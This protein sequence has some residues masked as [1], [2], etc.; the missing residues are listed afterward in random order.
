MEI[1]EISADQKTPV[2][3]H[4]WDP[5]CK[6][7]VKRLNSMERVIYGV[8]IMQYFDKDLG[9]EERAE[10]G[11]EICVLALIGEEGSPL[12]TLDDVEKIKKADFM[13]MN[14]VFEILGKQMMGEEESGEKKE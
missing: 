8:Q 4:E 14:R 10:A 7:F 2:D 12:L 11:A 1:R 13:P 6:A 9:A 3:I 5:N